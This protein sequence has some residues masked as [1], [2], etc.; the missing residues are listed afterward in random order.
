MPVPILKQGATLIASIQSALTDA[1]LRQ[2][3]DALVRRVGQDRARGVVVDVTALDVLDSFASRTLRDIV[4]MIR[5][6]GAETVVVGIQP[7]VAFAMVQLGL[8]LEGV[9]T[10]LDLEEGLDHLARRLAGDGGGPDQGGSG[11]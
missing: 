6:R 3:R 11:A 4:H 1:E 10:A 2:L 9:T 7:D 5:L 8:T